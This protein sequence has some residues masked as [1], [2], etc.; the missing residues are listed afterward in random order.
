MSIFLELVLY[1]EHYLSHFSILF[2]YMTCIFFFFSYLLLF[3]NC[4][5]IHPS[6]PSNVQVTCFWEDNRE[7]PNEKN[8]AREY[9][10]KWD[11][12]KSKI[13]EWTHEK[14]N[15]GSWMNLLVICLYY[16]YLS[17]G[18]F[19]YIYKVLQGSL[20]FSIITSNLILHSKTK[21]TR[22]FF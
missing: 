10:K 1:S 3:I 9:L 14:F 7:S 2:F 17:K 16:K 12:K 20:F 4:E 5:L 18:K 22:K 13:N 8:N 11:W 19:C 21:K 15:P 6:H